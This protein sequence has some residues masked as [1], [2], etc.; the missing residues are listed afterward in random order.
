ME[1]KI[2]SNKVGIDNRH[3]SCYVK[4]SLVSYYMVFKFTFLQIL[5]LLISVT[6][7]IVDFWDTVPCSLVAKYHMNPWGWGY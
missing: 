5:L 7:K 3:F 6:L 2:L 4:L 1:Q